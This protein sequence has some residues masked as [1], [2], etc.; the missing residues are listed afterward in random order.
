MR[1]EHVIASLGRP[2]RDNS[3]YA[4]TGRARSHLTQRTAQLAAAFVVHLSRLSRLDVGAHAMPPQR[5]PLKYHHNIAL[6]CRRRSWSSSSLA[7]H[8]RATIQIVWF[9]VGT[10]YSHDCVAARC[11]FNVRRA[12]LQCFT[13][14]HTDASRPSLHTHTHTLITDTLPMFAP[15][16]TRFARS[17]HLHSPWR[18]R[19]RRLWNH[20]A[21]QRPQKQRE[22][23]TFKSHTLDTGT[24]IRGAHIQRQ[25]K[26]VAR[27]CVRVCSVDVDIWWHWAGGWAGWQSGGGLEMFALR[28][29]MPFLHQQCTCAHIGQ[30]STQHIHTHTHTPRTQSIIL[31]TVD[32]CVNTA[33][34]N[35]LTLTPPPTAS[36]PAVSRLHHPALA[37][38]VRAAKNTQLA[39]VLAARH[40]R[41][42]DADSRLD[43]GRPAVR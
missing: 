12:Q 13:V 25:S 43:A 5:R 34:P 23:A 2:A 14:W 10:R 8:V 19:R 38:D 6:V 37:H 40:A 36:N 16:P 7:L 41:Q 15:N 20:T 32:Q 35:P 1:R 17:L 27:V 11:W 9:R 31:L 26:H 22:A 18:R 33:P 29:C 42:C 4:H 39:G 3:A 24:H 28:N 30:S 21:P